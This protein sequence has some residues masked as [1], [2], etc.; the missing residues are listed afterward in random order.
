MRGALLWIF[1][2]GCG[3]SHSAGPST[4]TSPS[5]T[6]SSM[7]VFTEPARIEKLPSVIR[8]NGNVTPTEDKT[9]LLTAPLDGVVVKP[10][11]KVGSFVRQNE[12]IVEMNS[13]YGMTSLQILERLEKEQGDVVEARTKLSQSLTNLTQARTTLG[14]AQSQV[15]SLQ[16][17]L[18]QAEVDLDFAK[19][20][21]KRKQAL[22]EV[23]IN[24]KAEVEE[25][26]TRVAKGEALITALQHELEIARRQVPLAENNIR[27]Y[28]EAVA[29]ARESV[30]ITQ[31]NFARNSAVFSQADL[32]GTELP[33]NLSPLQLSGLRNAGAAEASRFYLR[34]PI[35]GVLTSLHVTT[36]QR[37]T[38]GAEVGQ[39]VELSKVYVDANAFESDVSRLREGD[40]ITA[41][42]SSIPGK[43]F[44]GRIRYIGQGVN[45][46]TRTI[47]VR[48]LIE[49]PGGSLRPDMFVEVAVN[50]PPRSGAVIVPEK[51]L[52]TLGN[53]EFVMV[54]DRPGHYVK[55]KVVVGARSDE[56]VEVTTGLRAG[57]NV[58]VEG[59]LL[60]EEREH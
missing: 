53:E 56:K 13:V 38:S 39:V 1:I 54:E 49:N 47:Q 40:E 52:L 33:S 43:T 11:V 58:V 6:P 8:L 27:E 22:H 14:Q 36:G 51:A 26:Y 35:E 15:T 28:E 60:L 19:N 48:S 23:G 10:L 16:S 17:D 3:C 34:A 57:E 59:N 12:A 5:G 55:R 2:L 24:S 50:L 37:L 41:R 29:L 4:P 7:K 20:D 32:V 9:V 46:Q 25:A 21:W 44:R 30:T 42:T 31:S 18:R 45:P